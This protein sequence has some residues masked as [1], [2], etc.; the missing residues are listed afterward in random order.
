MW[1]RKH[2]SSA[3]EQIARHA[4][5]WLAFQKQYSLKYPNLVAASSG[6]SSRSIHLRFNTATSTLCCIKS[7]STQYSPIITIHTGCWSK[8]IPPCSNGYRNVFQTHLHRRHTR[9]RLQGPTYIIYTS[10]VACELYAMRYIVF[11]GIP[12]EVRRTGD[13]KRLFLGCC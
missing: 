7:W 1:I 13:L 2:S 9:Q 4:V 12:E 10:T 3:S 8:W 5:A 11:P 6:R